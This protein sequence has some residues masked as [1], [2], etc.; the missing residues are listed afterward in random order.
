MD[1]KNGQ[2]APVKAHPEGQTETTDEQQKYTCI[3]NKTCHQ[4]IN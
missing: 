1:K 3:T 4:S 2:I